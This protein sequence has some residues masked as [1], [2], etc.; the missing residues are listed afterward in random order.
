MRGRVEKLVAAI[1]WKAS[2]LRFFRSKIQMERKI[3]YLG[4]CSKASH[5][6]HCPAVGLCSHIL[7]SLMAEQDTDLNQIPPLRAQ[8]SCKRGYRKILKGGWDGRHQRNKAF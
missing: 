6:L 3:S 8:D 5:S 7:T 4:Q 1:V 2:L